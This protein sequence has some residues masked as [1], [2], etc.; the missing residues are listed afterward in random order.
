MTWTSH[1]TRVTRRRWKPI[2]G[3][4][5]NSPH[6]N[7]THPARYTNIDT[8][9]VKVYSFLLEWYSPA[10]MYLSKESGISARVWSDHTGPSRWDRSTEEEEEEEDDERA[11]PLS[12]SRAGQEEGPFTFHTYNSLNYPVLCRADGQRPRTGG[13]KGLPPY[14]RPL[15]CQ[16]TAEER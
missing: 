4:W 8:L 7:W 10:Q 13:E 2:W 9:C 12:A 14:V 11:Q 3:E 6:S 5:R 15:P 1:T 16:P